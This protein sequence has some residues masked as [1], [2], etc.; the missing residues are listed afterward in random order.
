VDEGWVERA[1]VRLHYLEWPAETGAREPLLL[2]HGLSSNARVWERLAEHRRGRRIVALDQR[3]H[4]GSDRPPSGYA[5]AELT[6]DAAHVIE[7][8]GL[9]RPVVAGHS[10]GAAVALELAAGF[11]ALVSGLVIVDGPIGAMSASMTWEEAAQRMQPPLPT[12]ADLQAAA[13]AQ[14]TYLEGAWGDDLGGFVEA[15]LV[16]SEAGYT[17]TLTAQVRLEILRGLYDHQPEALFPRVQGPILLALAGRTW[18]GAPSSFAEWKRRSAEAARAVRPDAQLRWYDSPHDIPLA[19]PAELAADLER[20]ALAASFW[21]VAR[22][23]SELE[24]DWAGPAQPDEEGWTRKDL[25]GHLSSSQRVLASMATNPAT[26]PASDREPAPP[27]DPDRWNASQIRR[28]KDTPVPELQAEL[29]DGA[30]NLQAALMEADLD[31]IA[32]IGAFAGR[33][34]DEALRLMADHQ[35]EHLHELTSALSTAV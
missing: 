21:D 33:P 10:W 2:L 19:R 5:A 25:L 11:P 35:R 32:V 28:R 18:G 29:R 16:R 14:A 23:A 31:R 20:T 4:G 26:P 17:S 7:A 6:A 13:A 8:L 27:F 34:L 3:S 15:G 9:G 12:Y 1:G 24:G 22:R 30:V